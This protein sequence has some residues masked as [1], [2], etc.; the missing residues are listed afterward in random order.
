MQKYPIVTV[1]AL[2]FNPQSEILLVKTHKWKNK[3]GI[4]GG[5]IDL[6][7]TAEVALIREIKEETNLEAFEVKFILV[8]DAVYS[9]EFHKAIHFIFLNY[10]C[11]VNKTENL[12][13]ND[14]AEEYE[15]V[16]PQDALSFDLN[17]PTSK[18]INH[19]IKHH[20]K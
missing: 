4:P 14:E 9:E 5:K 6:G 15:W 1:G 8:Q 19:F 3:Y 17:Q 16:K 7:E 18:L 2:I 20:A 10:A 13:L 12:R 11:K